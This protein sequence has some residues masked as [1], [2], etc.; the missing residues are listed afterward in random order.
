MITHDHL[1]L[2]SHSCDHKQVLVQPVEQTYH[3]HIWVFTFAASSKDTTITSIKADVLRYIFP[4]AGESWIFTTYTLITFALIKWGI[5]M[6]IHMQK[7]NMVPLWLSA[8]HCRP[9]G[10][11]TLVRYFS[12][13][14]LS[15]SHMLAQQG[16]WWDGG[17]AKRLVCWFSVEVPPLPVQTGCKVMN[18]WKSGWTGSAGPAEIIL[19]GSRPEKARLPAKRH[20]LNSRVEGNWF[21][22]VDGYIL[23]G[24]FN[25]NSERYKF[26]W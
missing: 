15:R 1:F 8:M 20:A 22:F 11:D 9:P 13:E 18:W 24:K 5:S 19:Q 2:S 7:D 25:S 12:L 4:R 3:F 21:N 16:P 17:K 23:W 26:G 10:I 14:G 6:D